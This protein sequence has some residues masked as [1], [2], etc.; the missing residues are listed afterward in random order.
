[1]LVFSYLRPMER[2]RLAVSC[3]VD[4]L[5]ALEAFENEVQAMCRKPNDASGTRNNLKFGMLSQIGSRQCCF[6]P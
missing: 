2:T 4:A 5:A 6:R 3:Y 1:M